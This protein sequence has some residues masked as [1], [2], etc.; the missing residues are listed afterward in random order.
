MV[1][2]ASVS[3]LR[4]WKIFLDCSRVLGRKMMRKVITEG[5]IHHL[6][7]LFYWKCHRETII[8]DSQHRDENH[9]AQRMS[10]L[11]YWFTKTNV[12]RGVTEP[13]CLKNLQFF[14]FFFFKYA[15]L[16]F[17]EDRKCEICGAL[18][19]GVDMKLV[20]KY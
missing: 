8:C 14:F 13:G 19:A 10:C 1:R 12:A 18:K 4:P 5:N 20:V 7:E 11:S 17:L 15:H 6:G 9:P 16:L 2:Q 3:R